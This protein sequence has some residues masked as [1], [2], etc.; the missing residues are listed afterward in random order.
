[1]DNIDD[2]I[3]HTSFEEF[4]S[5][6]NKKCI[7]GADYRKDISGNRERLIGGVA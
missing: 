5:R 3:K 7:G 4:V 1:M 2:F 6:K